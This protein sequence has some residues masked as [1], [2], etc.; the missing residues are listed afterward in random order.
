MAE[1]LNYTGAPEATATFGGGAAGIDVKASPNAFGV[2]TFEALH[3]IGE[4]TQEAALRQQELSNSL[5]H[6]EIAIQASKDLATEWSRYGKLEGK[7]AQ[8]GLPEYQKNVEDI[9]HRY[10]QN[11]P[12]D[13]VRKMVANTMFRD[14]DRYLSHG[15]NYADTQWRHRAEKTYTEALEENVNQVVI[16][17]KQSIDEIG[18]FVEKGFNGLGGAKSVIER[19]HARGANME[20][21]EDRAS[22]NAEVAQY[23]G[24]AYGSVIKELADEG[25]VVKAHDIFEKY[26]NDMDAK[27]VV[28]IEGFL[29]PKLEDHYAYQDVDGIRPIPDVAGLIPTPE[30]AKIRAE[31][32][33]AP[34]R[35]NAQALG[36]YKAPQV[37]ATPGAQHPSDL[38]IP[39]ERGKAG[40]GYINKKDTAGSHSYGSLGVNDRGG[41]GSSA[42]KFFKENAALGLKWTPGDRAAN[43]ASWEAVA[44]A[45]PGELRDAERK[46]WDREYLAPISPALKKAGVPA[47]IADSK[48]VQYYFADRNVQQGAG[49]MEVGNDRYH[50]DRFYRAALAANGSPE[51]FLQNME[52]IDRGRLKTDFGTAIDTGAY[53]S[54]SHEHRLEGR[55]Q[56]AKRASAM[57][58]GAPLVEA[59]GPAPER[60]QPLD[61]PLVVNSQAKAARRASD[62]ETAH[63]IALSRYPGGNP[64]YER[65]VFAELNRRTAL[66]QSNMAEE[67]QKITYAVQNAEKAAHLGLPGITLDK[68]GVTEDRIRSAYANTPS[69]AEHIIESVQVQAAAADQLNALK[70][71]SPED[72]AAHERETQSGRGVNAMIETRRKREGITGAITSGADPLEESLMRTDLHEKVGAQY[73]T[74]AERRANILKLDPASWSRNE[75]GGEPG[76]KRALDALNKASASGNVSAFQSAFQ[77]YAAAQTAAQHTMGIPD[78]KVRVLT[79]EAAQGMTKSIVNS[80]DPYAEMHKLKSHFGP[81][82]DKVFADAV[83]IGGLPTKYEALMVIDPENAGMLAGRLK[84]EATESKQG[85]GRKTMEDLLGK[86][87]SGIKNI[88]AVNDNIHQNPVMT[89]FMSSMELRGI[90]DPHRREILETVRLLAYSRILHKQEDPKLA[91]EAAVKAFTDKSKFTKDNVAI[92]AEHYEGAQAEAADKARWLTKDSVTVPASMSDRYSAEQYAALVKASSSWRS[93]RDGNGMFLVDQWSNPVLDNNGKRISV[94]FGKPERSVHATHM[95]VPFLERQ[96]ESFSRIGN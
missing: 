60:P 58:G 12:N 86:A 40:I 64:A 2:G 51:R 19:A 59:A 17:R 42:E 13:A 80:D 31:L 6:N 36:I 37:G 20:D 69:K 44:K 68:F 3:G 57:E 88:E 8:L 47:N 48:L 32:F 27:S 43:D 94:I 91:A 73:K 4:A 79:A 46:W 53:S 49:T 96:A 33:S 10:V 11:A 9:Y 61:S 14:A 70:F 52:E 82:W 85:E 29:K 78:D 15:A 56:L 55:M 16:H 76:V 92:P 67:H 7:A 83:A 1:K 77:D 63:R 90:S 28:R 54:K 39:L 26:K 84:V 75:G 62:L 95:H 24:A 89:Q 25:D 35:E 41:P 66:I 65:K 45:H 38:F 21:A 5:E 23:R 74:W 18:Q 72:I 87:P 93:N 34:T 50:G 71:A 81:S 30:A 22:V